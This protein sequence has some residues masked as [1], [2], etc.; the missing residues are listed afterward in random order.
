MTNSSLPLARCGAFIFDMDGTLTVPQHDFD[1]IRD[2]LNIPAGALI[3]EHLDK[4]PADQQQIKRQELNAIEAEIAARSEPAPALFELLDELQTRGTPFALLTRNSATN[5]WI[6]LKAIGATEYFSKQTV[7]GR[8]ETEPKPHPAGIEL[9]AER[10]GCLAQHCAMVGDYRH[11]LEAGTAAGSHTVHIR[12]PQSP[13][14]PDLTTT[15]V[16]NLKE[17]LDLL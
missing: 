6:S 13:V 4:L 12:H 14:W 10:L 7:I 2:A 1:A 8:D 3:L 5:A 9:L 11:D 17:L 16:T 15:T